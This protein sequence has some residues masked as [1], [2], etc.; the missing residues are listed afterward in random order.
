M[1]H[2]SILICIN[3]VF[4]HGLSNN[5]YSKCDSIEALFKNKYACIFNPDEYL[6]VVSYEIKIN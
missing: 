5:N 3:I 6:S 4:V 1:F 2:L